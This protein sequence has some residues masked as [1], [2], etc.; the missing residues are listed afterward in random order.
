MSILTQTCLSL[1]YANDWNATRGLGTLCFITTTGVC[2]LVVYLCMLRRKRLDPQ[3]G[4]G[5]WMCLLL[6]QVALLIELQAS[7][8]F[9][10]GETIRDVIR[11]MNLYENRRQ[12]Q[13][14]VF[15]ITCLPALGIFSTILYL[16]RRH[17]SAV[18]LAVTGTIWSVSLFCL[19]VISLHAVDRIMYHYVGPVMFISILWTFGATLTLSGTIKH[20]VASRNALIKKPVNRDSHRSLKRR[21]THDANSQKFQH[22]ST[23]RRVPHSS[24]RHA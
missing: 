19:P 8:R 17:G 14:M 23:N 24:N 22:Q 18:L 13:S 1:A 12:I 15:A 3:H 6:C 7:L 11:D 2:A 9:D 16:L 21:S 20:M 5:L 4:L 10:L